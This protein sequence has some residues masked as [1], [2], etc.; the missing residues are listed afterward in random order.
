VI[1]VRFVKKQWGA[2]AEGARIEDGIFAFQ[3]S[4]FRCIFVFF[5]T[6]ISERE[7]KFT[8]RGGAASSNSV[9]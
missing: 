2:S 7:L 3:N 4:A 8:F 5:Y 1:S 6:F 9:K